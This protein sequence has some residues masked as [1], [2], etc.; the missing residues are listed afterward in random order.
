MGL[1]PSDWALASLSYRR[2]PHLLG[3]PDQEWFHIELRPLTD[4]AMASI[5]KLKGQRFTFE[6]SVFEI[7]GGYLCPRTG[8]LRWWISPARRSASPQLTHHLH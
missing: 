8:E 1:N 7:T 3:G 5:S 6:G 4:V 2:Q